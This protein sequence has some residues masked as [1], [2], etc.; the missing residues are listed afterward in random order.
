MAPVAGHTGLS[1]A[2]QQTLHRCSLHTCT[3]PQKPTR[4]PRHKPCETYMSRIVQVN[5]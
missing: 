1:E 3:P 2:N 4:T 5:F